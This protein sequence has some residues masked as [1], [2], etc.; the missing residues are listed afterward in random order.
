[1]GGGD[2]RRFAS[3][4]EMCCLTSVVMC[5]IWPLKSSV[6]LMCTPS[7]LYDLFGGRYLMSVPS[8]NLIVLIWFISRLVLAL[9]M[10]FP[11]P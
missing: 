11:Y 7:I 6:G 5:L 1:L 4:R 10:G 9:L 8:L 2:N 3:T